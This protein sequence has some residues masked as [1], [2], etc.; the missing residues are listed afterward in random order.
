MV[1]SESLRESN[2]CEVQLALTTAVSWERRGLE[3]LFQ[4]PGSAS[5]AENPVRRF[6]Y[7]GKKMCLVDTGM[8]PA[9]AS[10]RLRAA[11]RIVRPKVLI[12]TG[13][14]GALQEG[15][16]TGEV[17]TDLLENSSW[18]GAL[19]AT[20]SETGIPFHRGK[21]LT[22]PKVLRTPAEKRW[23]GRNASAL[24][25]DMES[26]PVHRICKDAGIESFTLRVIL[27]EVE[28][29]IPRLAFW[30]GADRWK[31]AASLW[32]AGEVKDLVRL[33][34]SARAARRNLYR[35]VGAFIERI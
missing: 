6:F 7:Q 2:P 9:S 23:E 21:I 27:D 35:F 20:F 17:V 22:S 28:Q 16:K 12:V 5:S 30:W 8:G 33:Y 29:A 31:A 32:R 4:L 19:S 26:E 14:A 13:F 1:L 25:V 18:D 24:A 3:R 34:G 10:V 15:L 11:L